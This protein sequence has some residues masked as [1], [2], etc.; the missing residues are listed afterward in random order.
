MSQDDAPGIGQ[1]CRLEDFTGRNERTVQCADPDR[2]K[3]DKP[4]LTVQHQDDQ[5]LPV[6]V[7]EIVPEDGD[8]VLRAGDPRPGVERLGAFPDKLHAKDRDLENRET[9][10]GKWCLGEWRRLGKRRLV[11]RQASL[12]KLFIR[13]LGMG[14]RVVQEIR[15]RSLR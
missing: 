8:C 10:F 1:D 5:V 6:P 13:E 12:P 4:V 3:T 7:L 15:E 11:G 9:G 2:M 14:N